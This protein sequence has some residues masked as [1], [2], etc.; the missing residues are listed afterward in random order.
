MFLMLTTGLTI[1]VII[2]MVLLYY[3]SFKFE[4]A[5]FTLSNVN[6]FIKNDSS[7]KFKLEKGSQNSPLLTILHLSDFHLRKDK[8]GKK[9]FKFM[10]DLGRL[11]VD[12]IFITG[13]LVEKDKN[14]DYLIDMLF[15]LKAR[16]GKYAVF[17][18][19]DYYNKTP[20][21][22]VKNMFKKKRSYKRQND[23]TYLI[24]RLDDI[25]VKSLTN[26]NV[27]I[28]LKDYPEEGSKINRID[29]VEIIGLDDP[30]IEKIDIDRAFKG[31]DDEEKVTS[32]REIINERK[33]SLN[34]LDEDNLD[35]NNLKLAY[36]IYK[37]KYKETFKIK[38]ENVHTLHKSGKLPIALVHTPDSIAITELA[39]K[40]VDIIFCGHTHG[41]QVR[42]PKIGALISGCRI[43]TKFASGLFYLKN[44]VLYVSRGL[45]EGRYSPFRFFC[46][47]EAS[48]VKIFYS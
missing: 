30:I 21:E 29:E 39:E 40:C 22:F 15:P 10:G 45:G 17:G 27:K 16:Y 2:L 5:N 44:L 13:D 38:K 43:K 6:I 34:S 11:E 23:V 46:Q 37:N 24:S 1:I 36:R 8:K 7:N 32:D 33:A 14:I 4:P 12:F 19:H 28:R 9:L 35:R 48:L 41:G 26:E 3:Y 42:L 47:P 25:G 20:V 18:V 31:V